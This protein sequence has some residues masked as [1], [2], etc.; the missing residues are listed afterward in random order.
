MAQS[1]P[2]PEIP[3]Y[4]ARA[5][6][7]EA[8]AQAARQAGRR[9]AWARVGV[10]AA[11]LALAIALGDR[12]SL[13]LGWATFGLAM[14]LLFFLVKRSAALDARA[15]MDQTLAAINRDELQA[16]EGH[17][18]AFPQGLQFLDPAH[19]FALDLDLFGP[20]SLFQI[21]ARPGT[22]AGAR[23]L[24]DWL[25]Q[26]ST[27]ADEIL[28]RQRAWQELGPALDWRQRFQ[29]L[30]LLSAQEADPSS[31]GLLDDAQK[32]R[33]WLAQPPWL[34]HRQGLWFASLGLSALALA[35]FAAALAGLMPW[36]V[37]GLFF[38]LALG[39]AGA[40]VARLNP[41]HDQFSRLAAVLDRY[42]SMLETL[43]GQEFRSELPRRWQ[44]RLRG[45]QQEGA[46]QALRQLG[47]LAGLFDNRLNAIFWALANA[48]ASWD[49]AIGRKLERWK[50]RHAAELPAWLEVLA[51]F[52]AANALANHCHNHPDHAWPELAQGDFVL[53]MEQAAHLALPQQGRVGNDLR[54]AGLGRL[55]VV[56]G[57]NM[58][59]KST[60]LRTVGTSLVLAMLGLRLPA[61]RFR[62]TPIAL[63]T[64]IRANDSL[65]KGESY[66][67][68][69]LKRL[70]G[71]VDRLKQGQRLFVIVDEMLR[72][73]NSNDKHS[74]SEAFLLQLA[75]LPAAGLLA[76]HDV[77]LGQLAERLPQHF[78]NLC[79]EVELAQGQLRFDYRV[80]PGVS[81]SL[82]ATFLMRY[83]GIIPD[84]P[85]QP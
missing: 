74:G 43:E 3:D 38:L 36:S 35:S 63:H 10:F 13:T 84:P 48:F 16:R 27:R 64:S 42:A 11:G 60:F 49:L 66:F 73:T 18:H 70:K 62:F 47:R 7:F 4:A 8:R 29:A 57:A 22:D 31:K 30:A 34:L 83:M 77:A 69:E 40:R 51:Q 5:A 1:D 53:E 41:M 14:G 9:L 75:T 25:A 12:F 72:G 45:Q 50:L 61:R 85:T 33:A 15:R 26:P 19:P 56:T 28:E 24:A 76:T 6:D 54:L 58:A 59:G 52:E 82:N 68:A 17:W 37:A 65:E 23:Q 81:Q 46:S 78:S 55:A 20:A 21:L 44:E 80:R 71:L 39:N 2:A 79:F 32:L 67:Y